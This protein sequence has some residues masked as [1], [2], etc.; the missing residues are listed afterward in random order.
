MMSFLAV[1]L[2]MN[3][4]R[5]LTKHLSSNILKRIIQLLL[6]LLLMVVINSAAMI[7]LEEMSLGD[8]VWLSFTTLTTV[9]YGDFSPSTAAGRF[10]TVATMYVFAITLLSLL[11]AEVIEWRMSTTE[12]KRCG[13]WKFK[14]MSEHIQIINTPN[15]DTER[16]LQRLVSEIQRTPEF[17][18]NPIQLLTRKFPKGLPASLT[19]LKLL[20]RTG[21]AEDGVVINEINLEQAEHIIVIARDANDSLSDSIT[22]D[23]LSRI[24]Q[25]NPNA[26]IVAE[27][28]VDENR[29]RFLD[30]GADSV[31]RPIRAYPEM[32]VRALSNPGTERVLENLFESHGDSIRR[33]PCKLD[34][35]R[36]SDVVTTCMQLKIGTA[37]AYFDGENIVTQPDFDDLCSGC[38]LAVLI[39]DDVEVGTSGLQ[40]AIDKLA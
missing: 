11:A 26:N 25:I 23:I 34:N 6:L 3:R 31:V 9:G 14:D 21:A 39:K 4:K 17:E 29:Q 12:K 40:S 28:V 32:I 5:R 15:T 38:A 16:F 35:V 10:V 1:A 20:H 36:W 30:L 27:A 7:L 33:V 22:F 37:L 18:D 19:G 13:V 2:R 24:K 8:A